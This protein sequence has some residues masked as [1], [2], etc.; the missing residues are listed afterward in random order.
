MQSTRPTTLIIIKKN[1][2]T[3]SNNHY[4]VATCLSFDAILKQKMNGEINE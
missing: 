4:Q 1:K 3:Q 2:K